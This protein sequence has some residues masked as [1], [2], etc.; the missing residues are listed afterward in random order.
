MRSTLD[1]PVPYQIR[2]Q[3][4][5][6]AS[7]SAWFDGVSVQVG[8]AED[9]AAVTTLAGLLDQAALHG[10]LRRIRDLGL[11]L[12]EVRQGVSRRSAVHAAVGPAAG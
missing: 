12:I 1:Q 11:P 9:G 4:R 3:G 7:S 2:V 5:L 6:D 8:T 10:V